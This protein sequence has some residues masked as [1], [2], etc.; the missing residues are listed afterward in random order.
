MMEALQFHNTDSVT[1]TQ[2]FAAMMPGT[3]ELDAS[4]KRNVTAGWKWMAFW[5]VSND[6]YYN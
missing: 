3:A 5:L 4:T 2:R 1:R 6:R